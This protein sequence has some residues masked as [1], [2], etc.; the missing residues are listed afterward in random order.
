MKITSHEKDENA[1]TS[2]KEFK[3]NPSKLDTKKITPT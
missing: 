2:K 3:P 1:T